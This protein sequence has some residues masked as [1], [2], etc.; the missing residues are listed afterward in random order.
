MSP[1]LGEKPIA[2]L[3]PKHNPSGGAFSPYARP[4]NV[5]AKA[6]SLYGERLWRRMGV[7]AD[8]SAVVWAQ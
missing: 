4:S 1:H 2:M 8:G 3:L 6:N 7:Q 5:D